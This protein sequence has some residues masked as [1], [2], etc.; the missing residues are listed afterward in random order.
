MFATLILLIKLK[1]DVKDKSRSD[2]HQ[3]KSDQPTMSVTIRPII[4]FTSISRSSL[5]DAA[6]LSCAAHAH[7][8]HGTSEF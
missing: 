3:L 6:S 2:I 1:F 5:E 8:R 4:F 7:H